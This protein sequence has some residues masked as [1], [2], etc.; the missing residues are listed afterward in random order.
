[1]AYSPIEQGRILRNE[2]LRAI[3][4]RRG[5]TPAQAALAWLMRK[6]DLIAIPKAAGVEHVRDNRAALDVTLS[7]DEAKRLEAHY[8]P[9]PVLDHA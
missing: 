4:A 6:P 3:A 1:M 5:A 7:D 8:A 2:R 9:K